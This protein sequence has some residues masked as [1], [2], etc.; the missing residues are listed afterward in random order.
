MILVRLALGLG[1]GLLRLRA[2]SQRRRPPLFTTPAPRLTLDAS[3]VC[4]WELNARNKNMLSARTLA[5]LV[6]PAQKAAAQRS[7]LRTT[8]GPKQDVLRYLSGALRDF[9]LYY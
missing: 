3:E 9:Q 1:L 6:Q 5:R 2:L 4:I 8:P 7:D